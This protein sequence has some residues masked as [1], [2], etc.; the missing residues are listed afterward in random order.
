MTGIIGAA[1]CI[2]G[3]YLPVVMGMAKE[4]SGNYQPGFATFAILAAVAFSCVALLQRQWL[5]WSAPASV[6]LQSEA[7]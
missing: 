5:A 1:G 4:S 2:G 6:A 3:F 7:A